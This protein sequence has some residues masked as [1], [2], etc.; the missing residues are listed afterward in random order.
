MSVEDLTNLS[1]YYGANPEY[2]VAGGGNT[3]F[4]D[5]T[6]LYIKGSGAA[7]AD[8]TPDS[9]VRM[10]RRALSLIWEKN[11]P[12]DPEEREREVL[13]D[14]MAARKSGE[15][16]KR[17]SVETL[18]HDILPFAYV[19]HTH[20]ALL[21][22]LTCSKRGEEAATE[23]FGRD[24]LWIP[25]TNPGYI[26]SRA[27]K[28]AMELYKAQ[29]GRP[30]ELILLQNHGAF[31]GA[32]KAERLKEKY[33]QI[34]ERLE[35]KIVRRPD[36]GGGL[37]SWDC[38][39]ELAGLLAE[40]AGASSGEKEPWKAVF[41]RNHEIATLVRDRASFSPVSS[42]FTPDHIVYSGSDPLFIETGTG[43]I[44]D[45]LREAWKKQLEKTRRIPKIAA[46]QGLGVFGIGPSE[47]A[48]KL[49]LELFMDTIK[50]AVYA[51]SFGGE[52]F[53]SQDQIDF[54]NNWEVE[55]YR[56]RVSAE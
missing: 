40:L 12:Q 8:M 22:G 1:R 6:T 20:P 42:S 29:R 13:A 52:R 5:E 9:F 41:W 23:L 55:R 25:S 33:A 47:K 18:L 39:G 44:P 35:S 4:K 34:M 27:V 16:H 53:M 15:E 45:L 19:V 30:A 36:L 11:Y 24:A 38:S 7:L 31:V 2:V 54:I 50:V 46:L 14:M 17:P 26:L 48:A 32:D 3:S 10:D 28:I 49:S 56:S 51:Q 37:S 43:A 21:N